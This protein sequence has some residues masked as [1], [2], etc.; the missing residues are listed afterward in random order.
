MGRVVLVHATQYSSPLPGFP[1]LIFTLPQ[2]ANRLESCWLVLAA[3]MSRR[4]SSSCIELCHDTK[5]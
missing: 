1:V 4:Q 3:G 2:L 5:S